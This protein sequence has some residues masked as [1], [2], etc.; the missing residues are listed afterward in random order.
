VNRCVFNAI[1][2]SDKKATVNREQCYGCGSCAMTCPTEAIKLHRKER[3]E[4]LENFK[5]LTDTIYE[6]NRD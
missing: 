2:L 6:E 1:S 3:V 5:E 4:I